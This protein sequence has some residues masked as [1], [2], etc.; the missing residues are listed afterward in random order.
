MMLFR[1]NRGEKMENRAFKL[2]D[3][4]S[5]YSPDGHTLWNLNKNE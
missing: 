1:L 3:E 2:M 4:T 5:E